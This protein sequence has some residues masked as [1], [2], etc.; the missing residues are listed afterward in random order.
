[1]TKKRIVTYLLAT[2]ILSLSSCKQSPEKPLD[3]GSV[4]IDPNAIVVVDS[5]GVSIPSTKLFTQSI[6]V[7]TV[8]DGVY[9]A[10]I[11]LSTNEPLRIRD[12]KIRMRFL[13]D[14]TNH[15][16]V[17]QSFHW[18]PNLKKDSLDIISQHAFRSPAIIL[19]KNQTAASIIPDL[20]K[21]NA[22]HQTPYYLD[23][24]FSDDNTSVTYGLSN[25]QVD[26][27]VYYERKDSLFTLPT[28][29]ELGLYIISS[30]QSSPSDILAKTNSLLWNTFAS[31]YVDSLSP[32]V[33]PFREYAEKGYDMALSKYWVNGT[34][35]GTGGITL[36]TL[37]DKETGIYRGRDYKDDL[38]FHSWF[39][40]ARTAYGF[41]LW[42]KETNNK[43]WM[44]KALS[45]MKL[46][47][48][49][50]QRDGFFPT[51]WVPGN[52]WVS[53]GQGGG[54]E[55]Y[56]VPDNAWT[57]L[58]LLRFNDEIKKLPG[59]DKFL[60]EFA[61]GLMKTQLPNGCFPARLYTK[62]LTP[63][64][65]LANSAS[66][67]MPTW[68]LEE[69]IIRKKLP[70]DL[71]YEARA[72]IR[73]SLMFLERD[74]LPMLKFQDYEVFFSCAPNKP[75][76]FD[77][78]TWSYPHNTLSIQWSAEAFLS[79]HK[80]SGDNHDLEQAEYCLNILSLY[81]QV[82]SPPFIDFYAFGGF[83]VQNTDAEW[84]DARQAQFAETYLNFYLATGKKEYLQRSIAACRASFALMAI[85]ENKMISP[86]NYEGTSYNG[87]F[88]GAMAENFGHSGYNK[89][90][91]QSGFHWGT[92]SALTTAAILKQK[93]GDIYVDSQSQTAIGVDGVSVKAVQWTEPIK[94]TTTRLPGLEKP[95]VKS[96]NQLNVVLD[97]TP[98]EISIQ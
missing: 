32:Q 23:V 63:E 14:S 66:T 25:Y 76:D 64:P 87:E 27:H 51:I 96:G 74:V 47:L 20:E 1:M 15:A 70:P 52:K 40:N 49:S 73:R 54:P 83:G 13:P 67:A 6:I 59:A 92:G 56:H 81:Q 53:S 86:Q 88:I 17:K 10:T 80:I 71:D 42:G 28:K 89:R 60:V 94:L 33:L 84:S 12:L 34:T 26:K 35:P 79:A 85:P 98:E 90:S 41:Y 29:I 38:W 55:L 3:L 77:S 19:T 8:G 58:W 31:H 16:E 24:K 4:R 43:L 68:F 93:L 46:L 91:G 72:V 39:N 5:S 61:R 18:V 50:P 36:S 57:A 95:K 82:W 44:D 21:I 11:A 45:T 69:M 30:E 78:L 7:D 48:T 2:G 97:N 65:E 62:D 37:Q 75:N 9:H 22:Y